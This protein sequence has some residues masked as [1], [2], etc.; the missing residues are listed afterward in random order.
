MA[1]REIEFKPNAEDPKRVTMSVGLPEGVSRAEITYRVAG[2]LR[3]SKTVR[4]SQAEFAQLRTAVDSV[5]EGPWSAPEQLTLGE[6]EH[7]IERA[8]EWVRRR[9][10]AVARRRA[11]V[12]L[13]CPWCLRRRGYLGKMGFI[14]GVTGFLSDHPSEL[15]QQVF[16]QHAY[17]CDGCGSMQFFADG[18]LEHPLPGRVDPDAST[19]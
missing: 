13:S 11:A 8:R 12:D 17:R 14:T 9:E 6:A 1:G 19:R 4:A 2:G 5:Y 15:G 7:Y 3:G 16:D 18:F 10:E